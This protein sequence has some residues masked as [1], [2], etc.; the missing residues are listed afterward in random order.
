MTQYPSVAIPPRLPLVVK[1]SNRTDNTDTDARLVNC[2]IEVNADG[3]LWIF[4]RPGLHDRQ[5]IA[6]DQEGCGL[7][8]WRGNTYS[9]FGSGLYKDGVQVGT[10]DDTNGVYQFS[11]ILGATPKMV[12]GN[13]VKAYAYTVAGGLTADLHS[14]NTDFPEFFVK[15][16]AYLNG[17]EYVMNRQ[18]V[19]WGS[20]VNSVSVPGDWTPL[21]FISAQSE[22]DDGVALNKQ[23]TYVVAFN[24]WST[25]VFF[26]AGNPTGSPLGPVDGSL[27]N[28]G[29]ASADGVQ[30]IDNLLIWPSYTKAGTIQVALME[31]LNMKIV[32]TAAVERLLRSV[33]F[34]QNTVSLQIKYGGHSFYILSF[35]GNNLTLAYD[36]TQDM[37]SQW[38]DA[39][40]NWFPFVASAAPLDGTIVLQHATDGATYLLNANVYA[41]VNDPIPVD[42][43][44][45][46]FDANTR[47]RKNLN[48]MTFIA[49]QTA[50]SVLRVRCS[51]DDYQTWT[52]YRT[53]SLSQKV[54]TLTNCGTFTRRAYNFRHES[55]TPFRMQAIEVQYDLGTL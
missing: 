37:W 23:L 32:S 49:D 47:R 45:P 29:C 52:N 33:D 16:W 11:E 8:V 48:I 15:G 30:R 39:D 6:A 42:I 53:V 2:Y 27:L 1:P 10:V 20:R 40:G 55:N 9:V 43:Y 5:V 26:D 54:P 50:G 38:T 34:E 41:D 19:I 36:I 14:I 3:E 17:A 12:L 35:P 4:K 21:N 31:G 25:Q 44:T 22:P 13:G 28:Y 51:D 7:F 18:A 24:V 46:N